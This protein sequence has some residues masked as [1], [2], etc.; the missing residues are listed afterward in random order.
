M[1]KSEQ[2][3]GTVSNHA[4]FDIGFLNHLQGAG[5]GKKPHGEEN[6]AFRV[7]TMGFSFVFSWVIADTRRS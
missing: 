1:F 2:S 6:K 7:V 4:I 3:M 5:Y